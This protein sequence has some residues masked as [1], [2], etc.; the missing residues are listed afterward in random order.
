MVY[1]QLQSAALVNSLKTLQS[2]SCLKQSNDKGVS[3]HLCQVCRHVDDLLRRY[4][5]CRHCDCIFVKFIDI[6]M[7]HRLCV[8]TVKV[9]WS[10]SGAVSLER[11]WSDAHRG[12]L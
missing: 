6:A 11:Q 5:N 4:P 2:S 10:D 8:I 1:G 7:F 3:N 12:N 9:S